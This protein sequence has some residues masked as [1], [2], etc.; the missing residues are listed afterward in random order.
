[1]VET[2]ADAVAW[3]GRMERR[4]KILRI[5]NVPMRRILRLPFATP[6]SRSLMLLSFT[7]RKSGKRYEQP[8]SYAQ[9]GDVLLT[10]AGGRWKLNLRDGN[11]ISVRLRGR[12]VRLR[13]EF[14]RNVDEV[15]GLVDRM[16]AVNPRAAGFMPFVGP[17]GETDTG[18]L[19]AAVRH[20]FAIIR[21]HLEE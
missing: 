16:I 18:R 9:A 5:V 19:E 8:V 20:G 17:G 7:G 11:A 10:P 12:E 6:L 3:S 4:A 21:W 13:P 1:M 14:V 15:A 2:N